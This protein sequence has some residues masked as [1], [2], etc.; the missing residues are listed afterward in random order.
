MNK[1]IVLIF[2]SKMMPTKK[3]TIMM[4]YLLWISLFDQQEALYK[5]V[6]SLVPVN[7]GTLF[8]ALYDGI[9]MVS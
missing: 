8:W 9:S 6:L 7:K 1:K 3:K 5:H 2:C 4:A